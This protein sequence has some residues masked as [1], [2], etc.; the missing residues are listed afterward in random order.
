MM[1]QANVNIAELRQ[2]MEVAN[3]GSFSAAAKLL[4]QTPATLSLAI[5]RLEHSLGVRL[6]ER[7]TRSVRLT[8]QGR[9]FY[10]S[11]EQ[12]LEL[13][14]EGCEDI[15]AQ[16]H[17]LAGSIVLSAPGDLATTLLSDWLQDFIAQH[18]LIEIE[19]RVSDTLSSL[20]AEAV[21][22]AIRYG[23]LSDTRLIARELFPARRVLCASPAYLREHGV[24]S[25]PEQLAE[26]H[27]LCYKVSDQIDR[28]WR[29]SRGGKNFEVVVAGRLVTDNS[30]LARQ[31]ALAGK[32]L[33]YKSELDTYQDITAGRLSAVLSDYQ[34]SP[35]PL[36]LVYPQRRFVPRRVRELLEFLRAR[37]AALQPD[38]HAAKP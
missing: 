14:R 10:R 32:G 12:A 7:T 20:V 19:L 34:G 26:H 38:T 37:A 9:I 23:P 4:E 3:G 27:C 6:F 33:V 28:H 25:H 30:A 2:F 1:T 8:E 5:K 31:W 13:L 16:Q 18:P 36:Y 24:P 22:V 35:S 15:A 21:D 29:F 17:Q 11:C